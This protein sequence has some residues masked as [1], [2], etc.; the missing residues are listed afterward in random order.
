MSSRN[1]LLAVGYSNWARKGG[2]V[3]EAPR[4]YRKEMRT[5]KSRSITC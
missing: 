3:E 1:S 5:K 2:E 4:K